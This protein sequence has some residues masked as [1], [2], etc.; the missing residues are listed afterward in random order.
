LLEVVQAVIDATEHDERAGEGEDTED[1][2]R[3]WTTIGALGESA[4]DVF[5][6]VDGGF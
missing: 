6:V 4:E 1:C 2:G 3:P 5:D